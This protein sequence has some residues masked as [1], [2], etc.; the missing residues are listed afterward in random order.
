MWILRQSVFD[1]RGGSFM[2]LYQHHHKP[3]LRFESGE[4]AQL[5]SASMPATGNG[6]KKR[7]GKSSGSTSK[8]SSKPKLVQGRVNIKVPG[9]L[10]VQ[11]ISPSLLIPYLPANK[12]KLAAKKAL[13]ASGNNTNKI[14]KRRRKRTKRTTR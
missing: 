6:R 4:K 8:A 14:T 9:F 1:L 3:L 12:L 13:K 10:G 7:Q 5:I 11:K 2:S